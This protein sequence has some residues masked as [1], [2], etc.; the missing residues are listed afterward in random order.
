MY[1]IITGEVSQLSANR[2][3]VSTVLVQPTMFS[4]LCVSI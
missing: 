3:V 1:S 4:G 2:V